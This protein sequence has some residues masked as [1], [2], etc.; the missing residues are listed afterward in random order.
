MPYFANNL[1]IYKDGINILD[2][3]NTNEIRFTSE[4][5]AFEDSNGNTVE[6]SSSGT[7]IE[8]SNGNVIDMGAASVTINDNF[9]VSQ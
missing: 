1:I 4:G 9:E 5:I 6:M 8:D 2:G 7:K 3:A